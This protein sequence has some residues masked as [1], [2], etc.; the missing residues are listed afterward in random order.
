M[1]HGG[2]NVKVWGY[3]SASGPRQVHIIQGTMNLW[4]INKFLTRISCY[5]SESSSKTTRNGFR[6]RGFL[7]YG[8]AKSNF[9]PYS[10]LNFVASPEE[11]GT[12]QMSLQALIT[13]LVLQG[14]AVDARNWL[15]VTGDVW[16]K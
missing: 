5:R 9:G 4:L 10:N 11:V 2:G 14:G 3:F 1:K 6:E 13:G 16:L 12:C 8:L 15:V 7:Y